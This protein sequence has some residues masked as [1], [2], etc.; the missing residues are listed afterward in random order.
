MRII[1]TGKATDNAPTQYGPFTS[2]NNNVPSSIYIQNQTFQQPISQYIS[3]IRY[4]TNV[5]LSQMQINAEAASP[6]NPVDT[7]DLTYHFANPNAD[8]LN[9]MIVSNGV[10][11][12]LLWP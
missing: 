2:G 9:G 6:L 8:T 1:F 7:A 12:N 3:S 11:F 5:A 10:T 4:F